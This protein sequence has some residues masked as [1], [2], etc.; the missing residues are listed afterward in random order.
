MK[1]FKAKKRKR[2]SRKKNKVSY[3]YKVAAYFLVVG[4][5]AVGLSTRYIMF[6]DKVERHGSDP[7]KIL[8]P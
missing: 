2:R 5:M 8:T 7:M 3:K 4:L 6:K 1:P